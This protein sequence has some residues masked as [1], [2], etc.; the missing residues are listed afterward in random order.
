LA[1]NLGE[2]NG[3][4]HVWDLQARKRLCE[5]NQP[6]TWTNCVRISPDG[7]RVVTSGHPP[8]GVLWDVATAREVARFDLG[9]TSPAQ[10]ATFSPDGERLA[11]GVVGRVRLFD[12][13][14]GDGQGEIRLP[15]NRAILDLSF[16]RSGQT[17]AC[18]QT[19]GHFALVDLTARPATTVLH[20]VDGPVNRV[21]FLNQDRFVLCASDATLELWDVRQRKIVATANTV[22]GTADRMAVSRDGRYAYT[23]GGEQWDQALNKP[24]SN[25]EYAIRIWQLP[26]HVWTD[27]ND[28]SSPAVQLK[29][30]Q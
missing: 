6:L 13:K 10:A 26:K 12:G 29:P 21:R 5:L 20:R 24:V 16:N 27:L 28:S 2:N 1:S 3:A 23:A 30:P 18:G 19:G 25:G 22:K 17:L 11:L 14:S 7:K 15:Q 9:G 4:V 8:R